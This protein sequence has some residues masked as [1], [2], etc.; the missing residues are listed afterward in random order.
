MAYIFDFF[1][2]YV[3]FSVLLSSAN[4]AKSTEP[5]YRTVQSKYNELQIFNNKKKKYDKLKNKTNSNNTNKYFFITF[6]NTAKNKIRIPQTRTM[7]LW[8]YLLT[9]T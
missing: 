4:Y 2:F 5:I 7:I 8:Y 9:R 6:Q 1:I 3:F